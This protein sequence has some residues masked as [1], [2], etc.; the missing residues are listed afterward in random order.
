[1]TETNE[2]IQKSA[3]ARTLAVKARREVV[4][5][6]AQPYRRG[7]TE[8][9]RDT[10]VKVQSTIEALDRAA[11]DEREIERDSGQRPGY[12]IDRPF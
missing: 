12:A 10:L 6:L 9:I 7:H 4:E 1:M 2:H 8:D 11:A 5:A 3:T